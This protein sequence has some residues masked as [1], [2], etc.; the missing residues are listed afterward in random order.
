MIRRVTTFALAV[1]SMHC[2]AQS[3]TDSLTPPM[4]SDKY[5]R[6]GAGKS[7]ILRLKKNS[8]FT[9]VYSNPGAKTVK[10]SWSFQAGKVRLIRTGG[11]E[12]RDEK[13]FKFIV[14]VYPEGVLRLSATESETTFLNRFVKIR[15]CPPWHIRFMRKKWF[16]R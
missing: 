7:V 15:Y 14:K 11:G 12:Y 13:H 9:I 10:G 8:K 4:L 6:G 3:S 1:L 5:Y 2:V 16:K